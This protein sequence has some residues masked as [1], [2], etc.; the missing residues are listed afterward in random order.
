[1]TYM[2]TTVIRILSKF[3]SDE[4]ISMKVVQLTTNKGNLMEYLCVTINNY[5]QLLLMV[6]VCFVH[7]L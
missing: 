4:I 3:W 5:Y 1:M 2:H 7:K 6:L